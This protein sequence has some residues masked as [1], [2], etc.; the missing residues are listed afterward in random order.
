MAIA[1]KTVLEAEAILRERYGKW[2]VSPIVKLKILNKEITVL[3]ELKTPGKYLL[4]KDGNTLLDAISKAGD[5][6][7]YV[8]KKRISF[9]RRINGEPKMITFN[10]TRSDSYF[11]QNIQIQPGD[12]VYVSSRPGKSWDKRAGSTLVPIAAIITS[13]VLVSSLL[14]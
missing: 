10:L 7:I 4:E 8:N 5:F 9:V 1:G 11:T 2:V 14:K 3:G 13:I 6:D 12:I